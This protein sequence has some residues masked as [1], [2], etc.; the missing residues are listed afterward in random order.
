MDGRQ[1]AIRGVGH[2]DFTPAEFG[3]AFID[4]VTWVEAGIKPGGDDFLTPAAV[5][6]PNF[7]CAYTDGDHLLATPCP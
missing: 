4:L 2:C 1:R 5:A 6:D 3:T 7:G